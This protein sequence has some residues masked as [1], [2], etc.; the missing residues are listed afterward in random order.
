MPRLLRGYLFLVLLGAS[1][2]GPFPLMAVAAGL[3]LVN[4]G[5]YLSRWPV[6]ARL[7]LVLANLLLAPLLVQPVLAL[8]MPGAPFGW[9]LFTSQP[10]LSDVLAVL[11]SLPLFLLLRDELTREAWHEPPA[12]GTGWAVSARGTLLAGTVGASVVL[13]ILLGNAVALLTALVMLLCVGFAFLRAFW[14][15]S[16]P[17]P[18]LSSL[19]LRVVAGRTAVAK[20]SLQT[21]PRRACLAWVQPTQ[22]WLKAEPGQL[23]MEHQATL[24]LRVTPPLSG[25]LHP[26]LCVGVADGWGLLARTCLSR[27]LVLEVIPR[28]RYA[29]YLA[30]RFLA[31]AGEDDRTGLTAPVLAAIRRSKGIEYMGSRN[32]QQGDHL[33]DIDFKHS[34]KL[35]QVIA[36]DYAQASS[37]TA[38]LMAN[39]TVGDP[40]AADRVGYL[41]ISAALTL[42]QE[43][44]PTA[45]AVYNQQGVLLATRPDGPHSALH[46]VLSLHGQLSIASTVARRLSPPSISPLGKYLTL[47]KKASPRLNPKLEELLEFQYR[48]QCQSLAGSPA[49]E[50]LRQVTTYAKP[51][52]LLVFVAQPET[53][54]E[55]LCLAQL[56][57][58]Y[59]VIN[60][61]EQRLAD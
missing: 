38:I 12:A 52:A 32:Y 8:A 24:Q 57:G 16:G 21:R 27:P 45:L 23:V 44:I 60:L 50:A 42:A 59:E 40:E 47:A 61:A 15:L 35:G 41:L 17:L 28:A 19:K 29:R 9:H 7:V 55:A 13:S 53:Q 56:G 49:A 1:L 34:L 51:P 43:G 6:R 26:P 58:R 22:E 3:L 54:A 46:A 48:A 36:K 39:L 33:K 2:L 31:G 37:S 20:L 30:E 18:S 25:P 14:V 11:A 5:G 10:G 4:I